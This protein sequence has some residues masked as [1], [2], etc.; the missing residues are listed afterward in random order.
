MSEALWR[1][2]AH[3]LAAAV[4]SGAVSA[5]EAV[6]SSLERIQAVNPTLNAV[7]D[8]LA[9]EALAAAQ[10]ADDARRR[11]D[12]LGPLHG[13]PVTVKVNVDVKGRATTNGVVAFKD[14]LA[15]E[16]SPVVANLRQAG[17][18]IVGRT[19]TP[20]FSVRWFTE[21]D[22]HGRT[23]NPW[24][25]AHTPGG[26]SGGASSA[27]AAGMGAIAHGNDLAGSVRYPAYCTGVL[28][29]RPSF[30]R[31]PAFL[32]SAKDERPISMAMMSVQGPLARNVADLRLALQAMSPG[33]A[34]DPWWVPAPLTGPAL[35]R[36]LRVAMTV[37][38]HGA[39]AD[40]AVVAAVR[41]AGAW[42]ADAGYEVEEV[43]PPSLAEAHELWNLIGNDEARKFMWPAIEQFGD[44]GVRRSFGWMLADSPVLEHAEH[45]KAFAKRSTLIRRWQLFLQRYPL[46][47]GPVSGEPPFP[48]GWDV[49]TEA[50]MARVLR[51]Q[52]SQFAVPVL[53]LPAISV[54][55]G[56]AGALP[57]GVQL[58]APRFR[59]DLLLDAAEVIE[60][61]CPPMTPIDPR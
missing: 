58:I 44:E 23:L 53:G 36:P 40:P 4:R 32:P 43:E 10:A 14:N 50:S 49:E 33:D 31:V 39:P 35:P 60:S 56:L 37:N 24:S 41:Q 5:R 6:V 18:V 30:G 9:D 51:A 20:A 1:W 57:M 26:S 11:G 27:V 34:R 52:E 7:V 15:S 13:V 38:C 8:V 22:L 19:N 16:D 25:R 48:W 21:N 3:Q 28:G 47:L 55:T 61:R 45:L 17:A 46:V 59:E 54:P 12:A 29:L 2:S 42:L